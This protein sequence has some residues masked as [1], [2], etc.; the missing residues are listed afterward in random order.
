MKAMGHSFAE[1]TSLYRESMDPKQEGYAVDK[2]FPDII[3]VPEDAHFDL[4][5]QRVS[6]PGGKTERWIKLLPGHT[7]VR[8]SGYK[9]WMEKPG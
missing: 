5:K 7:Y 4:H 6:W 1:V 3:Y 9:V 2:R 8:P